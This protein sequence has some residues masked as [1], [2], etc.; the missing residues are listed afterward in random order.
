L[1]RNTCDDSR[2]YAIQLLRRPHPSFP[3]DRVS[4][5]P[6]MNISTA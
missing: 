6:L 5:T 1:Q 2:E 3:L 4:I